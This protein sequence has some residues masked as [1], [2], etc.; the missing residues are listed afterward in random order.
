MRASRSITLANVVET[1]FASNTFRPASISRST[2]PN[3][4]TSERL[5]TEDVFPMYADYATRWG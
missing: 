5:S 2:A 4:Q 3:G 1:S